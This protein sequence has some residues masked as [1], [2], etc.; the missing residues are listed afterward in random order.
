VDVEG[1]IKL[2]AT[3]KFR[4]SGHGMITVMGFDKM[5]K[6]AIDAEHAELVTLFSII[7]SFGKSSENTAEDIST[8]EF[9]LTPNAELR[10]NG[11]VLPLGKQP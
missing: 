2:N 9:E 4:F 1:M 3:S 7:Q 10:I 8:F 6:V 11:I 5:L